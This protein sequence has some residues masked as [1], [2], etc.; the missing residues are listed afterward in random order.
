MMRATRDRG[1]TAQQRFDAIPAAMQRGEEFRARVAA[2][3]DILQC[4]DLMAEAIAME[5]ESRSLEPV[6]RN[7]RI[8][9]AFEQLQAM[10]CLDA[11]QRAYIAMCDSAL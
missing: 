2:A 4:A 5:R 7:H 1:R 8:Y 11:A 6:D 9:F 10:Y 3:T